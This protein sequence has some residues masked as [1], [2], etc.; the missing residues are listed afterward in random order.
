[1][2]SLR[3]DHELRTLSRKVAAVLNVVLLV[4]VCTQLSGQESFGKKS[5]SVTLTPPAVANI[6]RGKANSVGLEFRVNAG[7]HINSNTPTQEYLIPTVLK[8][9]PPTDVVIGKITYPPGETT[10]F[11]FAPEEKLSVYSGAFPVEV[12]VRPLAHILPGKYTIRGSLRFQACDN[13][14]CYPPKNIPVEF[15]IKIVKAPPAPSK[16]PAQSPHA[17]S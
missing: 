14:Q 16:N 5:P 1:M 10:S 12:S 9:D 15:E 4:G 8:L 11:A 7:F 2:A 6:T 13:A 17:H 3:Q